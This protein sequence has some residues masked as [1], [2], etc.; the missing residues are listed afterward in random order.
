MKKLILL[1]AV[2]ALLTGAYVSKAVSA[3]NWYDAVPTSQPSVDYGART[4]GQ[5]VYVGW[6]QYGKADSDNSWTIIKLIYNIDG[7]FKEYVFANGNALPSKSWVNRATYTY[8]TS[9]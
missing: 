8:T 4:D 7:T 5:P 6:A 3:G 9:D 2:L 1:L